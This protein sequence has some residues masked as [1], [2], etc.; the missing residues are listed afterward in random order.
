MENN[1]MHWITS[2]IIAL[3]AVVGTLHAEREF[4]VF[5]NGL[6]DIKSPD[7]QAALLENSVMT[8]SAPALSMR[9]RNSSPRWTGMASR[10]SPPMSRLPLRGCLK[11]QE[12][13]NTTAMGAQRTWTN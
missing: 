7:D 2:T 5:D 11:N 10:S 12:K 6:T 3:F 4:F 8:A 13:R 1:P 9:R